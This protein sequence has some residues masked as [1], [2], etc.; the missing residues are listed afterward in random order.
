MKVA[1]KTDQTGPYLQLDEMGM[2]LYSTIDKVIA[3][4][5]ARHGEH[6]STLQCMPVPA[7]KML[8]L[9]II[10]PKGF[11]VGVSTQGGP[12]NALYAKSES[13]WQVVSTV[14]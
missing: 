9:L 4:C 10:F 11:P 1:S 5:G 14:V 6:V 7:P 12:T 3:P 8:P 2:V 13:G